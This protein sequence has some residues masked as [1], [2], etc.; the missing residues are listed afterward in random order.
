MT[1][2]IR[3][4][5]VAAPALLF[6]APAVCL[7]ADDA[8]H[9]PAK[10]PLEPN[11]VNTAVTVVVF[12]CLL[13]VLYRFAWGPIL[14]GLKA[15][16]EAE[17]SALDEARKAREEAAAMRVQVQAELAKAQD[18]VRALL[19]E[20]RK[21]A[22][23][24]RQREK[25]A[26]LKEAH[27]ERERAKREIEAAKDSALHEISQQAIDLAAMMSSKAMKRQ[28]TPDDHRRL[29]DESLAEL[30]HLAKPSA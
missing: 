19:D 1:A 8:G 16:E 28:I 24:L 3:R 18:Q 10:N 23:A 15:R 25:D 6:A 26:G 7:A 11:F 12:G 5:A 29:L 2:I 14:K 30:A 20:A 22:D 17:F 21:D 4:A 9:G 27:A 13:A